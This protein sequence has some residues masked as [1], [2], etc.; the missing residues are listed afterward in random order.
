ML[1]NLFII[2]LSL[3]VSLNANASSIHSLIFRGDPVTSD[4]QYPYVVAIYHT[5]SGDGSDNLT[6]DCTGTIIADQWVLTAG[7]CVVA[8]EEDD[9]T[10]AKIASPAEIKVGTGPQAYSLSQAKTVLSVE[11]IFTW[12]DRQQGYDNDHDLALL[13][14]SQSSKI[15]PVQLPE[16]AN[17]FSDLKSGNRSA[18]SLGY[19]W[20]DI[21]FTNWPASCDIHPTENCGYVPLYDGSL[22]MGTETI[23]PDQTIVNLIKQYETTL[24]PSASKYNALTMLGVVS[25]TGK[26]GTPGDSGGPLLTLSSHQTQVLIGVTSWGPEKMTRAAI[27]NGTYAKG[28]GIYISLL[29]TDHLTFIRNTMK[30]N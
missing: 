29:N 15:S 11:K 22:H 1:K 12:N 18:T 19:G 25:P 30:N 27:D 10:T 7:H 13:K 26:H 4:Q 14:L 23:Q 17:D 6:A 5:R 3:F 20:Q 21:Q 28:P 8:D 24:N 16:T 9:P 2:G